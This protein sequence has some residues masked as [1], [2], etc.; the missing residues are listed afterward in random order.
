MPTIMATNRKY[1]K[2]KLCT[3]K[4][5]ESLTLQMEVSWMENIID[6]Q[7]SYRY[8]YFSFVY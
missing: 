2:T 3:C 5:Q 7:K 8:R 1:E 4:F 6:R